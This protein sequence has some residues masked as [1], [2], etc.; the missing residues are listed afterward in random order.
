MA[1][2]IDEQVAELVLQRLLEKQGI[3]L[4]NF[5]DATRE[6]FTA[7]KRV[8]DF[9][10]QTPAIMDKFSGAASEREFLD[11]VQEAQSGFEEA[12]KQ[13]DE[14]PDVPETLKKFAS[15]MKP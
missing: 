15:L 9:D 10:Q 2:V 1:I 3:A 7:V 14:N 4:L 12:L 5:A 8:K 6:L 13:I 11:R